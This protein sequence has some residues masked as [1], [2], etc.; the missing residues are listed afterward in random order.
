MNP[1]D[2]LLALDCS[3]RWTNAAVMRDGNVLASEQLDIGRRQAAELPAVA[4]RVLKD[5]GGELNDIGLIA[6]TTG[7]G[8]FTGLRVGA[9]WAA[10]LAYGLRIEIVPV[11]TLRMLAYSHL[12]EAHPVLSMV[13]AG[14]GFVYAASFGC[15]TDLPPGEYTGTALEERLNGRKDI[16]IVSDDPDRACN[17]IDW[18]RSVAQVLP[19]AATV[20]RI[21]NSDRNAAISP[22]ELRISYHRA[23][24]GYI[25]PIA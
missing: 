19:D 20:A 2:L 4:E 16:A 1:K 17:A 8:Y 23:P 18:R 15:D 13:Y 10:A 22:M 21:A 14:H 24:Q 9:A 5:A 3:L 7:P 6:V 12:L 25:S 11:S